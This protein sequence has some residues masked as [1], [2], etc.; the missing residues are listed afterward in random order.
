MAQ[1]PGCVCDSRFRCLN[2]LGVSWRQGVVCPWLV[3]SRVSEPSGKIL[4]RKRIF[5]QNHKEIMQ[6]LEFLEN[7]VILI[8]EICMIL[9]MKCA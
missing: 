2:G 9:R 7:T 1:R 4:L 6:K 8:L 5:K 3:G